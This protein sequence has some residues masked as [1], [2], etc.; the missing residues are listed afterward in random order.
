MVN[1]TDKYL[2]LGFGITFRQKVMQ[3]QCK[4]KRVLLHIGMT[5][6]YSYAQSPY[7]SY[8]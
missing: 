8:Y 6:Q 4:L 5:G 1:S 3:D 7:S 2:Q